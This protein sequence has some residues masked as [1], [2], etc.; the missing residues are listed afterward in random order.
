MKNVLSFL[1]FLFF[2]GPAYT[3]ST[4]AVQLANKIADRMKDSLGLNQNKRNQ[5]YDINM[6]LH[7]QKREVLQNFQNRDS[8]ARKLQRIEM[9]RDSLYQKKLTDQQFQLYLSKKKNIINNN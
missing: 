7:Q 4:P 8:I 1:I 5:I 9:R 2:A 3:Q 6:K